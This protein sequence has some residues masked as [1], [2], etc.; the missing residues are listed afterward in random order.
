M[1]SNEGLRREEVLKYGAA[2]ALSLGA[3]GLVACGDDGP[4]KGG[5]TE[6][7]EFPSK[8]TGTLRAGFIELGSSGAADPSGGLNPAALAGSSGFSKQQAIFDPLFQ[9]VNGKPEMQLAESVEGSAD[10]KTWNVTLRDGVEFHDGKPLRPEDVIY[11]LTQYAGPTSASSF[12]WGGAKFKKTGPLG[13]EIVFPAPVSTFLESHGFASSITPENW[14]PKKPTG[15]T[16]A[17]TLVSNGSGKSVF[18]ANPNW[19]REGAGPYT[20]TLE[21]INFKDE[22]ARINALLAN[23]IDVIEAPPASQVASL[24]GQSGFGTFVEPSENGVMIMMD[25][26]DKDAFADVRVRQAMRL[27]VDRKAMNEQIYAGKGGIGNDILNPNSPGYIGRDVAQRDVDI[28]QAKSLLKAAGKEAL[29][30]ELSTGQIGVGAVEMAEVMVEQA[31]AAGITIKIKQ[32]DPAQFFLPDAGYG[33]RPFGSEIMIGGL[34][35]LSNAAIQ[36]IT[37]A[38]YNTSHFSDKEFDGL[39]AKAT[40][41]TDVDKRND[42]IGQMQQIE[43]DRGTLLIPEFAPSITAFSDK[44]KNVKSARNPMNDYTLSTLV[45]S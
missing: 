21:I 36:L 13:V 42:L 17:Y 4:K 11:S 45:L 5:G 28:E 10:A 30:V 7:V 14:D 3:L 40:A 35:Y 26:K 44:V 9:F 22:T 33:S 31:K 20:E 32:I 2:G 8:P 19:W 41:E 37:G 38:F 29:T 16:G 18:K 39:Y 23:Q 6:K 24:E 15:G 27:V 25:A 34:G 12:L 43:Y 1:H